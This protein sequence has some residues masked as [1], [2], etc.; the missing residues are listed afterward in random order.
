MALGHSERRRRSHGLVF[1]TSILHTLALPDYV[2]FIPD[3]PAPWA[4]ATFFFSCFRPLYGLVVDTT[5]LDTSGHRSHLSTI[6]HTRFASRC[7]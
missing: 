6:V 2:S 1:S 4:D 7:T 5:S 3:R